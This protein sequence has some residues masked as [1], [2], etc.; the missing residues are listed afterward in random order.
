MKENIKYKLAFLRTW[1]ILYALYVVAYFWF[2]S[3]DIWPSPANSISW[4]RVMIFG[5][6]IAL[7]ITAL[8]WL[9]ND[10]WTF[11]ECQSTRDED[12]YEEWT[13]TLFSFKFPKLKIT[14][15]LILF[16]I[17]YFG[18]GLFTRG[19]E[20]YNTSIVITRTYEQKTM[21]KEGFYDKLWKIYLQKEKI[22]NLNKET[23]VEV[24]KI[25]MENRKDG[26]NVTWKWV[27][28]NQNIPYEEFTRFYTDLSRFIETQR[29][30]YYGLEVQCQT[31]ATSNNMLLDTFPNNMYNKIINRPHITF[32]Y[33]FLSDSTRKVFNTGNENVQ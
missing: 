6:S 29:E 13:P 5:F 31:L 12:W 7:T 17:G 11:D 30:A 1:G 2:M 23:F 25:I 18:Y 24:S 19:S 32:K 21:E 27:H 20:I 9:F 10:E 14:G 15:L 22:T 28:E 4:Q 26:A 33:G 3:S 8:A 16:A